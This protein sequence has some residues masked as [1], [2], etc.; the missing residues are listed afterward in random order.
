M[1]IGLLTIEE[2]T[3]G[4][5]GGFGFVT[6]KTS[7]ILTKLGY[8]V[9]ILDTDTLYNQEYIILDKIP[10]YFLKRIKHSFIEIIIDEFIGIIRLIKIIKD[11][12]IDLII[13]ISENRYVYYLKLFMP[14]IKIIIWLQDPRT[15]TD[16]NKIF[17]LPEERKN[18]QN[19]SSN[20]IST[21]IKRFYN[22]ILEKA[23][24]KSDK[25]LSQANL[26]FIKAKIKWG[27]DKNK[28]SLIPNPIKI[29]KTPLIKSN[30]PLIIFLGRLDSIKRPWIFYEIARNFPNIDFLVLGKAT[31][32]SFLIYKK[33]AGLISDDEKYKYINNLKFEGFIYGNKK[34]EILSKAWILINTSIYEA[35]PVSFLEALSYKMAILSCQN[36]DLLTSK[37][38][39][40]TGEILG[41]G[42]D[43]IDKFVIGLNY[44]LKGNKWRLLGEKG[45]LFV[46]DFADEDKITKLLNDEILKITSNNDFIGD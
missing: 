31:E 9:I 11:N 42:Y 5:Y 35:L 4:M 32:Q 37:Y 3:L 7:E 34:H 2:F 27:I 41:Y 39:Y 29:P 17:T 20:I 30:K 36:P 40:Y 13:S 43:D 10:V 38:G 21:I 12:K 22:Y 19:Q 16:W 14:Y 6:R 15:E 26:I 45:Y 25:L 44:L 33:H 28:I 24:Y 8:K 46:K 23:I 1:N 18:I